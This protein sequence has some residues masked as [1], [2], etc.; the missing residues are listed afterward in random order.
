M[1]PLGAEYASRRSNDEQRPPPRHKSSAQPPRRGLRRSS[2]TG[3]FMVLLRTGHGFDE[4]YKANAR[5]GESRAWA[6]EDVLDAALTTT[7]ADVAEIFLRE[8]GG[9]SVTLAG[10]RGPYGDEFRQITRFEEG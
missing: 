6:I 1:P 5:N 9:S 8:N 2:T 10:F 7:R 4:R 3:D